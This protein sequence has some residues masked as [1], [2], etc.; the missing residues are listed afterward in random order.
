MFGLPANIGVAR[1]LAEM[2]RTILHIR[3][4]QI[5]VKTE[6]TLDR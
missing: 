4:M 2:N 3:S 5:V 6:V 1:E